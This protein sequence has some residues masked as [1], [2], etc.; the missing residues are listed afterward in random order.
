MFAAVLF[1]ASVLSMM[2]HAAFAMAMRCAGSKQHD[3]NE[4]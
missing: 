2:G 3:G 1:A 4:W